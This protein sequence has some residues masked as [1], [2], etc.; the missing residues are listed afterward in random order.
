MFDV[1]KFLQ[2]TIKRRIIILFPLII[3]NFYCRKVIQSERAIG[4][5]CRKTQETK[6][7]PLSSATDKIN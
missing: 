5:K 6:F 2:A 1:P 3:A 4:V 7:H